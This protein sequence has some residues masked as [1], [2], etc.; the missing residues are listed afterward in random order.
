MVASRFLC[1]NSRLLGPKLASS[2]L[3][4]AH[5]LAC[6][7]AMS[8][9]GRGLWEAPAPKVR[10]GHAKRLCVGDALECERVLA[11]VAPECGACFLP[12]SLSPTTTSLVPLFFSRLECFVTRVTTILS[13]PK[14][15]HT[16]V[17]VVFLRLGLCDR[18][19][20]G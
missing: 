14:A 11:E 1:M 12:F 9:E 10:D 2:V 8:G 18:R 7:G 20:A 16:A 3:L 13:S 15:S 19:A 6:W 4:G 5:I 17:V